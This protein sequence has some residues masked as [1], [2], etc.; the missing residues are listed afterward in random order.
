MRSDVSERASSD[1]PAKIGPGKTRKTFGK[2]VPMARVR[3]TPEQIIG[4][5]REATLG[6][7]E[8]S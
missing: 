7:S 2:G 1:L 4:K 6:V 3:F 8:G 5:L